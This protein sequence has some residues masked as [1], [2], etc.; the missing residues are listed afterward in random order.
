MSSSD[1]GDDEPLTETMKKQVLEQ[2]GHKVTVTN[3]VTNETSSISLTFMYP[4]DDDEADTKGDAP[5]EDD[6]ISETRI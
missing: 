6:G 3:K 2:T 4:L 5:P 1:D